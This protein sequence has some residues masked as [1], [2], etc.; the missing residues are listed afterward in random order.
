MKRL[1]VIPARGGSKRIPRKNIREFRG[2]PLIAWPI[3]AALKSEVFDDV[4]VSTDDAEI[5]EVALTWGAAVPFERPTDLAGD[6]IPTEP[7]VAHAIQE[8]S[9]RQ[10]AYSEVCCV[11]PAAVFVTPSDLAVSSRMASGL[12]RGVC[13]A[14]VVR[15]PHPIQRALMRT[16]GGFL[17]PV[18]SATMGQRSQDLADRWHDA[19][20]FYWATPETWLGDSSVL[21]RIRPYALPTWRVQ[22][23]D[24][25]DD[26]RRA[27]VLFDLLVTTSNRS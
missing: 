3:S 25:F 8:M 21:E 4:I 26:W 12:P 14:T 20:Q 11:Y 18:E 24:T 13:I 1:A 17:E 16:S 10:Q 7:V 23:I 22:D 15:Y 6:F 2:K 9:G 27:E 19:G 5:A